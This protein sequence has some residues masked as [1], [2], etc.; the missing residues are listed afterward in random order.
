MKRL[1]SRKSHSWWW[2]SHISP[3]NS[4]WLAENLEEMDRSVK[5]M[6]K[7]IEDDGDSFAKKAEM[8]YHKRPEL[9]SHVEEFY[10]MYRSLAERYDQLTGE[11]RKNIP[12]DL[13]SQGSDISDISYDLPSIWPSSDQRLSRRK[14]GP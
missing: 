4:R 7:L 5:Q 12:S 2:D 13:Q 11:L 10:R 9:V 6:L 3:K 14:S 1:E 8:Y